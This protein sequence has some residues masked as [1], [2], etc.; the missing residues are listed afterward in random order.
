MPMTEEANCC[1]FRVRVARPLWLVAVVGI[2]LLAR[3]AWL[4]REVRQQALR[5]DV[6]QD[7]WIVCHAESPAE[8]RA[9][10]FF[11]LVAAG[12]TE[13]R[14]AHLYGLN[15]DGAALTSADLRSA[16]FGSS[17]FRD[18]TLAGTKLAKA[19]FHQADVSGADFT[20]ANLEGAEFYRAKAAGT[21][22]TEANLRGA[23]M[24]VLAAPGAN[25][26]KADA[27][28]AQ[29]LMADLSGADLSGANFSG[30]NLESANL[31][32]ANLQLTRLSGASWK[33]AD[34]TDAN[35]WRARGLT[36]EQLQSLRQRFA[37]STNATPERHADF[38]EWLAR[39]SSAR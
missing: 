29:L 1:G 32:G 18:A 23:V 17:T 3:W 26:A 37:P 34:F 2:A 35:W 39:E 36:S 30:A 21:I 22:F 24:H 16:D 31:R 25:F 15:F 6:A 11:R 7:F 28:E 27:G 13:W 19:R 9:R 10:S 20:R 8:E 5:A 14:A 4:E 38:Q 33:D 12:N